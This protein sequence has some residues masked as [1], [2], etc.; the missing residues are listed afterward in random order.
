[1][2]SGVGVIKFCRRDVININKYLKT[3]FQLVM[4]NV[5]INL[6]TAFL[7][8]RCL[9]NIKTDAV[10]PSWVMQRYISCIISMYIAQI[11]LWIYTP[12][13]YKYLIKNGLTKENTLKRVIL[14]FLFVLSIIV[15]ITLNIIVFVVL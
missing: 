12:I 5:V 8:T 9:Y 13:N 7:T 1:M 6:L 11:I 15:P 14:A 10:I 4:L 3:L 2:N